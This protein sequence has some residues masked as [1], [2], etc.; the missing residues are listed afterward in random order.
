MDGQDKLFEYCKAV[1]KQNDIGGWTK[2]TSKLYPHQWLWDSCFTAIGQR[3]ISVPRAQKEIKTLFRGQ[4]KNGMIPNII[5][6]SDTRYSDDI[7]HSGVAKNAPKHIKTSG[8]TQPPM[9]AEAVVKI[10]EM[11]PKAKRIEWYKS[12]FKDLLRYHEWMYRERDPHGEGLV[13]LIHPWECGLDNT[14]SWM[15]EMHLNE[16]PLW[17]KFVKSAKLDSIFNLL[18]RDTKYLPAYERIDTIDA[19]GLY[20]IVR[21][22]RRKKYETRLVLRHSDL[23]IEDL[24]FNS[25]LIRANTLLTEITNEIGAEIPG[26]L[27]ERMKKAPHALELLW[28]EHHGQYFSRNF[29]T[30]ELIPEPS[31]AAFLP[32]YAGTVSKKRAAQLVELMKSRNW[33]TQY[34]LASVPKNSRYFQPVKYWQGPT[35]INTNWLIADGLRR[36]GY[37]VEANHIA[38]KSLELVSSHGAYEYFSPLD[39]TPAG[40][41]PFSWTA[42]LTIDFIETTKFT[43]L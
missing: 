9:I 41:H 20:S 16:L 43:T 14:P 2:P 40:A 22:L 23:T 5:Y 7:W 24:A 32:L 36:Y 8:I 30:F 28:N 1:L 10:G 34:P 12:I 37:T 17:I 39:G 21:N 42:A 19:L 38:K 29:N 6:G 35:W 13:V 26:W 33:T 25:I 11:L 27:W 3:H 31:V 15:S 18:R 4:W